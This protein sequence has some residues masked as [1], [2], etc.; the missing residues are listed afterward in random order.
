MGLGD[1]ES[2]LE[3]MVEG[4]FSRVFR[5][6]VRPVEL[7][8]R[9][10]REMDLKRSVGVRGKTV[11]P[12][13]F[14]IRLSDSDFA[15]L[16]PMHDSLVRELRDAAREH[17]RDESYGFVGPVTV[18]IET[19]LTLHTGMFAIVARLI[20][21]EGGQRT[22]TVELAT[23]GR[24]VLGDFIVTIGRNPDS[25]ITL[26]DANVS[27]NHAEI[28][29]TDS[30]FVVVDLGSTNG[31]KVNGQRVGERELRDADIITFGSTDVTFT[32]D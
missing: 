19:D 9:L 15:E 5:S 1:F 14:T 32:L 23:G 8:R 20:E 10:V 12:N 16:E 26:N 17:A 3:R 24:V 31:T 11:V 29:P 22:G 21:P 28:R 25:T 13:S 4:M 30:G 18:S 2:R 27:R 6:G 7:G